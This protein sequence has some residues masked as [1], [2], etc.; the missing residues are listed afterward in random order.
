MS[1]FLLA[2]E[3]LYEAEVKVLYYSDTDLCLTETAPYAEPIGSTDNSTGVPENL[4]KTKI[5]TPL[6]AADF[7]PKR[8]ADA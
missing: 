1:N 8:L 7:L 6:C 5:S 4:E 2:G 3:L